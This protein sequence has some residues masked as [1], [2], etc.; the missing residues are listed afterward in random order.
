MI[1]G[2]DTVHHYS[3]DAIEITYDPHRCIHAEECIRKLP[4]VF[5][6]SRR[7]WIMPSE[8]NADEIARVIARCPSGALHFRRSD[9]GPNESPICR[10]RLFH[11]QE[12]R[13]MYVVWCNFGRRVAVPF[14]R[15]SGWRSAVAVSHAISH[16]ATTAISIQVL[17]ILAEFRIL[18]GSGETRDEIPTRGLQR[19][20][21]RDHHYDYGSGD[22]NTAWRQFGT[23]ATL[24]PSLSQLRTELL[25]RRDLLEQPPSHATNLH[26][27][28]GLN[29]LGQLAP[30]VLAF[31]VSIHHRMDGREPFHRRAHF[32][33]CGGSPDGCDRVLSAAA[34]DHPCA[35]ERFYPESGDRARLERQT[36][37][38]PVS[39]CYRCDPV[40]AED[41]SNDSRNCRIDLA[42]A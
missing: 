4:A 17:M 13:S 16:S 6:S 22:E 28:D 24:A 20:R 37:A 1:D 31:F 27:R 7:P 36:I 35:R 40:L 39:C 19:R 21:N 33:I 34:V 38:G 14:F 15:T 29:A 26:G 23:A 5:D 10:Q 2:N 18:K 30:A 3:D 11:R 32:A 9:G 42:D 41:R 25:L 8:A 12:D